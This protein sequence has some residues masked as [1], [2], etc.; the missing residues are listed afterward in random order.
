MSYVPRRPADRS[1]WT[2]R[3]VAVLAL[4]A[5]HVAALG[6]LMVRHE[7]AEARRADPI[8]VTMLPE[9]KPEAAPKLETPL[10]EVRLPAP[11]VPVVSINLPV[12]APPVLTV[13]STPAPAP[14]APPS[15]SDAPIMATRVEYVRPPVV[16]Y[17]ASARQARATGTVHVRALVEL[18]GH[19]RD[20]KVH[21]SSGHEVLDRAACESVLAALFKPYTQDGVPR[22][23]LVIVPIDFS[24]R[25]R[26]A[27]R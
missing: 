16:R 20:A 13:A 5:I 14:P 1:F 17:P 25:I 10:E 11:V 22:S 27:S 24:L 26:T 2:S 4:G 23:A 7:I 12:E 9:R 3:G 21:R 8:M 19:V 18:D 15:D 6:A